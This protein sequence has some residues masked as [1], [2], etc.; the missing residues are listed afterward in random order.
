MKNFNI[1]SVFYIMLLA[2]GLN[3]CDEG[4][5]PR[6]EY[7]NR[8]FVRISKATVSIQKGEDYTVKASFDSQ[9]T[10]SQKF[11]WRILNTAVASIAR[12]NDSTATITGIEA[13]STTI[14]IESEDGKLKYF[15]ILHVRNV[16]ELTRPVYLDFGVADVSD[17]PF[18]VIQKIERGATV[19]DLLDDEGTNTEYSISNLTGFLSL[20]VSNPNVFGI[21]WQAANDCFFNDGRLGDPPV[22]ESGFVISN[23]KKAQSYDFYI[24]GSLDNDVHSIVETEFRIKGGNEGTVVV[25]NS[26]NTDRIYRVK[27]IFP[28]GDAQI[29]IMM[30]MGPGNNFWSGFY[31][32]NVIVIT[33]EGYDM[34][35]PG[36]ID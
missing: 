15:S 25:D 28:D 19:S 24:Y 5:D 27:N 18:N 35:I 22:S 23:L 4:S 6:T 31:G 16:Y 14:A 29:T 17:P 9:E 32:V 12:V 20:A 7:A 1:Q 10:A 30:G 8:K 21:P 34:Q 13:G 33:P 3:A 26:R 2:L 36:V 11:N